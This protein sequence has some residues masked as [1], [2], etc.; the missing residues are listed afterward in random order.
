MT[1]HELLQS[2]WSGQ[3]ACRVGGEESP[4]AVL[5]G[6]ILSVPT[7]SLEL[8]SGT[9]DAMAWP[10][11]EELLPGCQLGDVL[12]EEMGIDIPVNSVILFEPPTAPDAERMSACELGQRLG[13]ILS[14]IAGTSLSRG[15]TTK[16]DVPI[17]ELD[18]QRFG[19]RKLAM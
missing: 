7:V 5:L 9:T 4:L 19:N 10:D 17:W 6:S 12:L 18:E 13:A 16:P 15:K 2:I 8:T 14:S 3:V 11:S 1:K